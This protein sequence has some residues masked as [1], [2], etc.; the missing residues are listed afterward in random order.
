M[1]SYT[2]VQRSLKA[3]EAERND[4][5]DRVSEL[6][7]QNSSLQAAKRKAEQ[8]YSTLQVS[9]VCVLVIKPGERLVS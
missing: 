9:V 5:S 3:A 7:A 8:Q 1:C 4:Q 2:Q 6:T